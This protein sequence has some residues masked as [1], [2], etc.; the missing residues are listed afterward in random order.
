MTK[1][2]SQSHIASWAEMA[3][4]SPNCKPK[5]LPLPSTSADPLPVPTPFPQPPFP[6]L[7][8]TAALAKGEP[9]RRR[10]AGNPSGGATQAWASRGQRRRPSSWHWAHLRRRGLQLCV[11][12][13]A[14]GGSALHSCSIGR[15]ASSA[16]GASALVARLGPR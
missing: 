12:G 5:L 2:A 9:K 1:H 15:A 11:C 6:I 7:T 10:G 14:G 4:Y 13:S 16:H 3:Y 8:R